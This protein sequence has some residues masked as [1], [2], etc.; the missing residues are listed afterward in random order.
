MVTRNYFI[1]KDIIV[2][3]CIMS[4]GFCLYGIPVLFSPDEGRYAEIAREM[5]FDNQYLVPYLD[6]IIY[7]EKPPLMYWLSAFFLKIFG[8][9]SWSARLPNPIFSVLGVIFIYITCFKIFHSRFI[10][11]WAALICGTSLLYIG[12]GRYLNLDTSVAFFITSAMLS[13]WL[14]FNTN[15]SIW[16][17]LSF[18]F[19]GLAVMSKGLIGFILPTLGI[20][21]WIVIIGNY[22]L[23]LDYRLILGTVI[24]CII[25]VPWMIAVNHIHSKFIYYYIF[26]QHFMR[27]MTDQENRQMN[28][29]VYCAIAYLGFFPWLNFLPQSFSY[30]I[31]KWRNRAKN[32]NFWFPFSW[33]VSIFIFF[34]FSKSILIGYLIP[35]VAPFSILIA[36]HLRKI[37]SFKDFK[38]S[39]WTSIFLTL[40]IIFILA[41]GSFILPFFFR[42]SEYFINIIYCFWTISICCFFNFFIGIILLK[43]KKLKVIL[44]SF[45]LL[46]IF[47]INIGWVGGE[48]LANKS[49]KPLTDIVKPLLRDYPNA[50]V[51]NF[52]EYFY[53]TQF[54]LRRLTWIVGN[55]GELGNTAKMKNSSIE[56]MLYSVEEFLKVWDGK[57]RIFVLMNIDSYNV[58]FKSNYKKG[59][60]LGKSDKI[61]LMTNHKLN[62]KS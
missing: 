6:G 7:F 2:L 58:Y 48:Y 39:T 47:I 44:L 42:E 8:L 55:S 5:V 23:L 24:V 36:I 30:V 59:I 17:Y 43:R 41:I 12:G 18:C 15:N 56:K 38:V 10:G 16:L 14:S 34:L 4:A 32:K 37:I 51:A 60:L 26:V 11:F 29:L 62:K 53:D 20:V 25:S 1:L 52:G 9:N 21:T 33:G 46:M 45:I 19:M 3:I 40:V 57:Q 27:Y 54:Y 50:I 31:K 35:V 61:V 28:K 49:V 22:K 13:Y